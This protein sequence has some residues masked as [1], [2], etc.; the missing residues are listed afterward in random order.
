MTTPVPDELQLEPFD[1]EEKPESAAPGTLALT[2]P[3]C[4]L[5]WRF[6]CDDAHAEEF[7]ALCASLPGPVPDE[8]KCFFRRVARDGNEFQVRVG[9]EDSFGVLT[10]V[11]N[12]S[13]TLKAARALAH[14]DG[15][16]IYGTGSELAMLSEPL[17]PLGPV[18]YEQDFEV[19]L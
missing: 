9:F 18:F 17:A 5:V 4:I 14:L 10:H 16:E 15:L 8:P 3:F 11:I 7:A 12:F 2:D 1:V 19:A 13:P 6:S